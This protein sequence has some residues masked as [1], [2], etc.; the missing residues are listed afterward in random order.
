MAE[1]LGPVAPR[2]MA[3]PESMLAAFTTKGVA[4]AM[5]NQIEEKLKEPGVTEMT[6][7]YRNGDRLVPHER[8]DFL[9]PTV[10]HCASP[11]PFLANTEYMFPFASVVECPQKQMIKTIGPT[12]VC[13]ALT[14]NTTW[15]REL[16]DATHIDRLNVGEVK[17]VQLNWLQ[18]HE[19]NIIDFMFRNR[20]FQ[21]SPPPAH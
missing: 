15:M 4:E 14:E 6:A 19:G 18:P 7:K 10:V 20:A 3:D 12:L 8:H 9:R 1:K 11:E 17:T 21:N 13:T 2:S 5:N 16:L